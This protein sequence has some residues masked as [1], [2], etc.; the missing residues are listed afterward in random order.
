MGARA[1]CINRA[2]DRFPQR[3]AIRT[4]RDVADDEARR[5]DRRPPAA[6]GRRGRAA[7]RRRSRADRSQRAS[8]RSAPGDRACLLRWLHPHRDRRACSRSRPARSRA[9]CASGMTKLRLVARSARGGWSHDR[10]RNRCRRL[11]ARLARRGRARLLRTPPGRRARSAP[12]SSSPL[13]RSSLPWPRAYRPSR[14][15]R[16][17]AAACWPRSARTRRHRS[18]PS[19]SAPGA[20]VA[21]HRPSTRGARPSPCARCCSRLPWSP[22]REVAVLAGPAIAA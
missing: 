6:T 20:R 3:D 8:R 18:A 13:T 14:S 19:R 10:M 1:S 9:G 11:F 4:A 17:C 15:R 12:T 7:R 22:V 2:I 16:I 21:G 5:A